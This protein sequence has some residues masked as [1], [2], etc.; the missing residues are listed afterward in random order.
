MLI[1]R[2]ALLGVDRFE[3]FYSRLDINRAALSSRLA[4]LVEAGLLSREPPA[5]KRATY[6]L[7]AAGE[8]LRGIFRDLAAWGTAHLPVGRAGE[9]AA[10]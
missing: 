7:T 2:E 5:A 10:S 3:D 6:R 8:D 4:L 9:F 1:L